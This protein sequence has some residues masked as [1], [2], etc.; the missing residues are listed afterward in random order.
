MPRSVARGLEGQALPAMHLVTTRSMG[1]WS[2]YAKQRETTP[3]ASGTIEHRPQLFATTA[4]M[5]DDPLSHI[6]Y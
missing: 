4:T 2:G 1:C 3:A 6:L 5:M